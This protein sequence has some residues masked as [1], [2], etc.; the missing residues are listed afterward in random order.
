MFFVAPGAAITAAARDHV[1]P[2][3]AGAQFIL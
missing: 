1:T 2:A 3:Q